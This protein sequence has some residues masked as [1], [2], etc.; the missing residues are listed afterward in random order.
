MTLRNAQ[1]EGVA[2]RIELKTGDARQLPFADNSFD[3]IVSSWALHNIYEQPG[4]TKAIQEIARVLRPGGQVAIVDIRHAKEYA[5]VLTSAGFEISCHGP[6]LI[7]LI[8]S[9]WL[10]GRKPALQNRDA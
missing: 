8:P 2:D 7:F 5:N 9:Y 10:A 3:A 1:L 4:R 6:S